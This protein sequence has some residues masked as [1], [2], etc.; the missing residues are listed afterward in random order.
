MPGFDQG[1]MNVKLDPN[2]AHLAD[3]VRGSAGVIHCETYPH[4]IAFSVMSPPQV[5]RVVGWALPNVNDPLPDPLAGK[6]WDLS[7]RRL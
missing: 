7:A 5:N 3:A 4:G 1:N 6:V 2:F